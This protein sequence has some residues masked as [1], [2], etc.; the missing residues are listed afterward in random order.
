MHSFGVLFILTTQKA[1]KSIYI[2][3]HSICLVEQVD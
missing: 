1:F 3:K 2:L